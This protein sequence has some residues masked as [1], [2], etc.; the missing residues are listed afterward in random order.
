MVMN[1]LQAMLQGGKLTISAQKKDGAAVFSIADTGPGIRKEHMDRLFS[2]FFTTKAKGQGLGLPVCKRLV[3]AHGG[4][5][6]VESKLGKGSSFTVEIPLR[7]KA[8][9]K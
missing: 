1:A 6:T 8:E 2:P 7:E 5:I 9:V 3:E 4:A